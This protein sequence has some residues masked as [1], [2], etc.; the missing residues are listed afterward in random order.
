MLAKDGN[1]TPKTM[2]LY[3]R[4]YTAS[5]LSAAP[6][7][8]TS[9]TDCQLV[10]AIGVAGVVARIK[11]IRIVARLATLAYNVVRIERWST[12]GTLGSAVAT[13][14]PTQGRHGSPTSPGSQP[15]APSL[16]VSS[17]GTAAYTTAG[18]VTGILA[19]RA[20]IA[21]STTAVD[22]A[23]DVFELLFSDKGDNPPE[24]CGVTDSIVITT[25]PP[26]T[27]TGAVFDVEIQWEEGT[28]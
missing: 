11:R 17:I 22:T 14:I 16:V 23:P 5:L 20:I 27:A 6:A 19:Q 21:K 10:T 4:A 26:A 8:T 18:T 7:I 13:A 1:G 3:D 15:A 24:I 28:L 12:L 2:P 25:K 9:A